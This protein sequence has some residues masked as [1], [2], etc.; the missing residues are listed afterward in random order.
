MGNLL[1]DERGET[2]LSY[3]HLTNRPL[4]Q[5]LFVRVSNTS[6]TR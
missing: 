4:K 2:G 3:T 6:F 1:L 5:K